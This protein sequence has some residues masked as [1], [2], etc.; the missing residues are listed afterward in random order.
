MV[1]G[2]RG[3]FK[4]LDG[5]LGYG[6]QIDLFVVSIDGRFLISMGWFGKHDTY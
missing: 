2:V 3:W 5:A 1:N 4:L 6:Y